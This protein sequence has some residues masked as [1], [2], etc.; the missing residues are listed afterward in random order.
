[1]TT[2]RWFPLQT[3]SSGVAWGGAEGLQ[4]HPRSRA[5]QDRK[6]FEIIHFMLYTETKS[7]ACIYLCSQLER[8]LDISN[9][10]EILHR[11][12]CAW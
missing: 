4:P 2:A 11:S 8:D 7:N 1:M 10:N 6:E 5:G 9:R 3:Q 12:A